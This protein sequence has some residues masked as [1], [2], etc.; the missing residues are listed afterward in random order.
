MKKYINVLCVLI[1]ALMLGD[2]ILDFFFVSSKNIE[3]INFDTLSL[4]SLLGLLALMFVILGAAVMTFIY[5]IRFILNV[6]RNQIFTPKNV[7]LLR[8]YGTC[9]ILIG[10]SI[11]IFTVAVVTEKS[12]ADALTDGIDALVE[13]CFALLMAEVFK[14][15]IDLQE[16]KHAA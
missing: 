4:G 7:S 13:G 10:V 12:F 15:G 11:T 16:G 8:K 5:F 2:L 3:H 1:L 14:I 9:A 6:N